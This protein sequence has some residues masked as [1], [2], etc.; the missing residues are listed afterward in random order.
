MELRQNDQS[1]TPQRSPNFLLESHTGY[2]TTVRGPD[3]LPNAIVSGY[4]T[5]Y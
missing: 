5:F 4:L 2:Y 1:L 3:I